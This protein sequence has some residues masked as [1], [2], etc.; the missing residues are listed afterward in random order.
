M[1]RFVSI[2]LLLTGCGCAHT[3]PQLTLAHNIL[4]PKEWRGGASDP[5][6]RD[7][8]DIYRYTSAYERGWWWCVVKHARDIDFRPTCSDEFISGWA[9]ETY[10]W[11]AGVD[12][13]QARIE[14][15]IQAYGKQ[16]VSGLLSDFKDIKLDYE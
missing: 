1:F 10:G 5:V 12:D 15:L 14:Q 4:V 7:A 13:A 9:A 6:F 8:S 11:P 16:R 2:I 3:S